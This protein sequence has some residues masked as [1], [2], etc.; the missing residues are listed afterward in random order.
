MERKRLSHLPMTDKFETRQLEKS[1]KAKAA[2]SNKD[3]LKDNQNTHKSGKF[4]SKMQDISKSD[5]ERK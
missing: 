4:F 3:K 5:S 2:E 1:L